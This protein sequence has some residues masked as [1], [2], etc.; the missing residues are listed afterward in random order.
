MNEE[1]YKNGRIILKL[2]SN[3]QRKPVKYILRSTG[4]VHVGRLL[5]T[6]EGNICFHMGGGDRLA[7][8]FS[9]TVHHAAHYVRYTG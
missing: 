9:G 2:M 5:S 6:L 8:I 4:H 1:V 7:I 3:I